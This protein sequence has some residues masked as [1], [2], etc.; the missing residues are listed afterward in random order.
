MLR[1]RAVESRS[2]FRFA[3]EVAFRGLTRCAVA[4]AAAARPPAR[5]S[6]GGRD[7]AEP[8]VRVQGGEFTRPSPVPLTHPR[9]AP[10]LLLPT[11]AEC[12]GLLTGPRGLSE[13]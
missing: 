5:R 6:H 8:A 12:S 3:P 11:T 10:A 9:A 1:M 4:A 2:H 13:A 7:R